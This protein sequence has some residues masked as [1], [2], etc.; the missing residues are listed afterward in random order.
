MLRLSSTL[1]ISKILSGR[2]KT[3]G[4]CLEKMVKIAIAGGSGSG[5]STGLWMFNLQCY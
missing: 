2:R 3:Y 5:F 1:F 4:V